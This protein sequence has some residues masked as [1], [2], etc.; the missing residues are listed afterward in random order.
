MFGDVVLPFIYN[1]Q[2]LVKWN[3][4]FRMS[5]P[6]LTPVK[7]ISTP[8]AVEITDLVVFEDFPT[9]LSIPKGMLETVCSQ[10]NE[11]VW[12]LPRG[13]GAE[14]G[15]LLIGAPGGGGSRVVDQV[16]PLAI[17]HRYGPTFRLSPSDMQS[18][19]Q[20]V[21]STNQNQSQTVI[22]FYRSRTRTDAIPRETDQ[23]ILTALERLHP[24]YASDFKFFLILTPISKSLM[25]LS[26]TA[27]EDGAW[28]NW[29]AFQLRTQPLT[30]QK[31]NKEDTKALPL[32]Q[33]GIALEPAPVPATVPEQPKATRGQPRARLGWFAALA[34]IV[35]AG[36]TGFNVWLT[37]RRPA[38]PSPAARP[39]PVSAPASRTGFAANPEGT[40][41]KLTWN[42]DA[43]AAL[44]PSGAVLS[45]RDGAGEQQVSL[46][47]ADLSTGTVFYTPKT[48]S[49]LF[50]LIVLIPGST[51]VEEHVRVLEA[52]RPST[53]PAEPTVRIESG[54]HKIRTLRPFVDTSRSAA[55]VTAKTEGAVDVAPPPALGNSGNAVAAVPLPLTMQ[56]PAAPASPREP[57]PVATPAPRTPVAATPVPLPESLP[58]PPASAATPPDTKPSY[59]GPKAL[60]QRPPSLPGNVPVRGSQTIQ[61]KVEIGADGK[62]TRVTPMGRNAGNFQL[63]D[64]AIRAA[65]F[66]AFEPAQDHG[67]PVPSEMILNFQF[68]AK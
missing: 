36:V 1:G 60:R 8:R 59:I 53:P 12:A 39:A 50:S 14:V 28:Q 35:L 26:I 46:T 4:Y 63:V 6:Q 41:W 47:D 37:Q 31:L 34:L 66:W 57:A 61:L 23:E 45:I 48:G 16:I 18:L 19:E 3:R 15:G 32:R 40:M 65:K 52:A 51:A 25:E 44:R 42:R 33:P 29:Q 49:L 38:E 9:S 20:T 13:G 55:P 22:G 56:A 17:E 21:V 54:D 58:P 5:A 10:V 7:A 64:A 43:V 30:L 11:G 27:R 68:A 2:M 24:A 67:R 62:V